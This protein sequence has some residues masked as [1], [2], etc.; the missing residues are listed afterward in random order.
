LQTGFASEPRF[1]VRQGDVLKTSLLAVLPE[2]NLPEANLLQA[3]LPE[4]A[5]KAAPVKIIGNIPY[6]ITSDILLWL[7]DQFALLHGDGRHVA[8]A[9]VMMQKEVAERLVAKPRT[10]AYGVLTLATAFVSHAQVLFHVSPN[11]FYPRPNVTSSVVV[12]EFASGDAV[13]A[14]IANYRNVYPLVRTAFN[15]RRKMLSNALGSVL[16]Q[17]N[18]FPVAEIIALAGERGM[19]FQRRA[20][21]LTTQDFRALYDFL[22]E[23]GCFA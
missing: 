17:S 10:K 1:T 3:N 11:C 18:R 20:E 22:H 12:F 2:A 21:E 7:F 14:A 6:Y 5:L 19:S 4:T 15:Q 23:A 13:S 9:V 8:R 16:S